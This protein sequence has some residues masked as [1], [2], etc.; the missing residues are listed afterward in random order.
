MRRDNS[1]A[2]RDTFDWN[3]ETFFARVKDL[4][5]PGIL[6]GVRAVVDWARSLGCEVAWSKGPRIGQALVK[7]NGQTLL[8]LDTDGHMWISFKQIGAL[9]PFKDLAERQA[10]VDSLA[11]FGA[12]DAEQA[13]ANSQPLVRA[14][15][16]A[17][18]KLRSFVLGVMTVVV[19]RIEAAAESTEQERP[20][21]F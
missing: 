10:I 5:V 15:L 20:V 8:A 21:D 12:I 11:S 18:A 14:Q 2:T 3:E 4:D 17:D 1:P 6:D 19:K 16:I 9:H 13:S 7:S